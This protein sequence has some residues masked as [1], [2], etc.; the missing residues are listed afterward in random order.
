MPFL[1]FFLVISLPVIEVASIVEVSRLIGGYATFLLLAAGIAFGAFLVRSQSMTMGRRVFEAVQ[2]GTPPEQ[3]MLDSGATIFAGLLFMIPGFFTDILA[4]LLLFPVARRSIWRGI[5]F[6]MR[7]RG[8]SAAQTRP[9]SGPPPKPHRSED[10]ID[11]EF[12][13][14]PREPDNGGGGR[15]DSPWGK[16]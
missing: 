16:S 3:T 2:A 15:K 5:A 13:E 4:L 11:V 6:G 1:I 9:R 8:T 7:R 10:V 12:T 14:V